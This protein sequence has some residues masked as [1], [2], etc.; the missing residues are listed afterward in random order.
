MTH[1][2]RN[3]CHYIL[4]FFNKLVMI[5]NTWYNDIFIPRM[6][7]LIVSYLQR[8]EIFPYRIVILMVLYNLEKVFQ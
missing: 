8:Y 2:L 6:N 5:T 7:S 4:V 3:M 1:L